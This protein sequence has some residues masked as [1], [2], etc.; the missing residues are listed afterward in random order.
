M[1]V[2]CCS[3]L[4]ISVGSSFNITKSGLLDFLVSL[5]TGLMIYK[6]TIFLDGP[7]FI[8]YQVFLLTKYIFLGETSRDNMTD[9]TT[10]C[11]QPSWIY[12]FPW[13]N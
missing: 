11:H 10:K 4:V 1:N 3:K 12:W 8:I 9:K 7:G 5:A 13:H 2:R 6:P